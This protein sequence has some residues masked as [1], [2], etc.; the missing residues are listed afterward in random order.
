[1]TFQLS[2][3]STEDAGRVVLRCDADGCGTQFTVRSFVVAKTR[4]TARSRGWDAGTRE[5]RRDFCPAHVAERS[6]PAVPESIDPFAVRRFGVCTRAA[7][8]IGWDPHTDSGDRAVA[9]ALAAQIRAEGIEART[10]DWAGPDED[11]TILDADA[12]ACGVRFYEADDERCTKPVGHEASIH[13]NGRYAWGP[14]LV[15]PE[16]TAEPDRLSGGLLD[17]LEDVTA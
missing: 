13:G 12:P 1:M 5:D 3:G 10:F 16:V 4:L 6:T 9:L 8:G 11:G 2:A 15:V 14:A 17:L 7:D